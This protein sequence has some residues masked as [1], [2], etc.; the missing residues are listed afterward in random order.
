MNNGFGGGGFGGGQGRRGGFNFGGANG[1]RSTRGAGSPAAPGSAT[2]GSGTTTNSNGSQGV[3]GQRFPLATAGEGS[4]FGAGSGGNGGRFGSGRGGFG[5][6]FGGGGFARGGGGGASTFAGSQVPALD[7]KLLAYLKANQGSAKFLVATTTSSYASLFI[8]DTN[9]PAM[10]LGGYQGWDR[11][12]TLAQLQQ[13]V[14]NGTIRFFYLSPQRS[15]GSAQSSPGAAGPQGFT[16]PGGNQPA[17]SQNLANVNNDLV[18]WVESACTVVPAQQVQTS[19]T[20]AS[21]SQQGFG[22]AGGGMQ[23]YD[24]GKI[25]TSK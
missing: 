18:S 14:K 1:F 23:L 21:T 20:G 2:G 3:G 16:A 11:I 22:G 17:A 8:L 9:Q 13:L 19:T 6:G 5:G 4:G 10:A 24:C 15:G 7:P 12:L 25:A